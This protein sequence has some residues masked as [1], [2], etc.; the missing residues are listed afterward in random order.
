MQT[1]KMPFFAAGVVKN[2]SHFWNQY[3]RARG[4]NVFE[5]IIEVTGGNPINSEPGQFFMLRSKDSK[6]TLGR[7]IS[8]FTCTRTPG[9]VDYHFL[10]HEKGEGT[11]ELLELNDGDIVELLGPLGNGFPLPENGK[12]ICLVGGGIGVAPIVNLAL[13]L[14][15]KSYDLYGCFKKQAFGLDRAARFA[16][17]STLATE[18]GIDGEKGMLDAILDAKTLTDKKYDVVYACG[19]K[20]MLEYVQK[21]CKKTK[22]ECYLSLENFMACGVGACLGCSIK[23]KDGNKKCCKDGPVFKGSEIVFEKPKVE[24]LKGG[25]K[26]PEPDLSVTIAGQVFKNPVIA[27]SGTFGFGEEY[28]KFIDIDE[29]GGIVSKGLTLDPRPGN[30]G[31]RILEVPGGMMNSIGLENPGITHFCLNELARMLRYDTVQ[32]ANLSGSTIEDYVM[33]AELLDKTNI[34]M[35]ELNISC[36]NVKAGGMAFGLDAVAAY[37]VTLAV[38]EATMKPLIV[39]LS[40]NATDIVG[41]ANAVRTAGAN[42]ISLVNTFQALAIDIETGRPVFN[43]TFAGLSGPGIKP[44]ALRIVY[45]VAKDMQKLPEEQRIPII[46]LG[47]ISTWHDAVEFIL[48]GCS[49]VQ[50]GT[51]TF[52]NPNAMLEIVDGIKTYMK[53]HNFRTI[54]SFRGLSLED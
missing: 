28:N 22:I 14:K 12:N 23:T 52:S 53:A 25:F 2:N 38:R 50:V 9:G 16:R 7:P 36:P 49:A 1:K 41:V 34:P 11:K 43:N 54:E 21:I 26:Y 48:A 47:G 30:E 20:P 39:K 24:V 44:I 42:A 18:S 33:G 37:D 40:P 19:P 10:I 29:L 3:S 17:S 51:A 4:I 45:Q 8:V 13:H 32:I 6:H 31:R 15:E 35:I 5:L 27:A 46:G